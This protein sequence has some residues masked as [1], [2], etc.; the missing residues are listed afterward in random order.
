MVA[1]AGVSGRNLAGLDSP[2]GEVGAVTV[3]VGIPVPVPVSVPPSLSSRAERG[4]AP[5]SRGIPRTKP[6]PSVPEHPSRAGK[7]VSRW[8]RRDRRG[9]GTDWLTDSSPCVPRDPCARL[10]RRHP[11]RVRDR[12]RGRVRDRVRGR[13]GV[14]D[15]A[16]DRVCDGSSAAPSPLGDTL[17]CSLGTLVFPPLR[18]WRSRREVSSHAPTRPGGETLTRHA[19]GAKKRRG[20]APYALPPGVSS[21]AL[22]AGGRGATTCTPSLHTAGGRLR[23]FT[24]LTPGERGGIPL[25]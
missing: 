7:Q 20:H 19:K 3:G 4:A 1:W 15:R 10:S 2:G 21:L 25:P 6:T 8:D 17:S 9:G 24:N 14:R 5:R 23:P 11:G 12:A 16:G 13:A 22:L 18:P